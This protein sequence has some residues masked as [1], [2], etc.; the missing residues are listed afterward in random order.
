MTPHGWVYAL[1]SSASPWEFR[2]VGK[3]T[4]AL[5][6]RLRRHIREAAKGGKSHRANWIRKVLREGGRV[7][8]RPVAP[9][10]SAA[11]LKAQERAWIAAG[12][13]AELDLCNGTEGGEG[14]KQTPEVRARHRAAILGAFT[15]EQR[16]ENGR[17]GGRKTV[18][19]LN[20][21]PPEVRRARARKARAA[22]L[23]AQQLKPAVAGPGQQTFVW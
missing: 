1:A 21:A 19:L 9:Y 4:Q 8:I 17:K 23:A 18:A 12:W 22:Q 16:R 13:A 3:T 11:E 10:W 2:Y 20:S 6:V 14:D 5:E 15:P 7:V